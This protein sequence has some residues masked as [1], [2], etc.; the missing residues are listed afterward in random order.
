M[1]IIH[2][3]SPDTINRIAAGEVIERPASIVK[4]LVENA[5][6]AGASSVTVDVQNGGI[7]FLRVTD[8]GCG[9]EKDDIP[10]AFLRHATSKIKEEADLQH[11]RSL[12]FRGEALASI[13]SVAKVELL[14]KRK[15]DF[16]GSRY[17]IEGGEEKSFEDAGC[18]DGTTFFI[19]DLFYNVPARRKFLKSSV[20]EAGY[21]SETMNRFAVARSDVAFNVMLQGRTV[22]HTS[23]NGNQKDAIYNMFGREVADNLIPMHYDGQKV[24]IRGYIGKSVISRG[25]RGYEM[26]FV[27]GRYVRSNLLYKAIEDAYSAYMMQHQYPFTALLFELNPEELDVNIHP[28]KTDVR[29][30]EQ[31]N[32]CDEIRKAISTALHNAV[33][34]PDAGTEEEKKPVFER[35]PEVFETKRMEAMRPAN[36]EVQPAIQLS[37]S[38]QPNSETTSKPVVT[39]KPEQIS[40]FYEEPKPVQAPMPFEPEKHVKDSAVSEIPSPSY[41]AGSTD[42]K[43]PMVPNAAVQTASDEDFVKLRKTI[44]FRIIGQVFKTYWIIETEGKMYIIDQHAAH[45]KINYERLVKAF[46]SGENCSQMIYPSIILSLSLREEQVLTEYM[47]TFTAAG[48][49]IQ[50]FGGRDYQISAVPATLYRMDAKEYFLAILDSLSEFNTGVTPERVFET[51]A[52]MSCK[53][54]I[55]G[56]QTISEMEARHLFEELLSLDNPFHCPHGRPTIISMTEYELER[57]F[58]RNV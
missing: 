58:K 12:G 53:A 3:L 38:L 27:N 1:G 42:I 57:K 13:A 26:Y 24:S 35:P 45:E 6:D 4:E 7:S 40:M 18:P 10:T 15:E 55:K 54:A 25:N 33:L 34:I 11:I 39:P 2:L 41:G 44:D 32:V 43:T 29:F 36:P 9:M 31:E 28:T 16:L 46:E 37:Q 49:V 50:H 21:I 30:S 51:M 19:R 14:T 22:L 20:T 17:V 23:G 52:S 56:N 47:D 8:N 5:L 48:F